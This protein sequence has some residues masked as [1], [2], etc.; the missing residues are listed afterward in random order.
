MQGAS[1]L[2]DNRPREAEQAFRQAL[3]AWQKLAT[4][5]PAAHEYTI[6]FARAQFK[7]AVAL[8]GPLKR[9][10]DALLVFRDGNEKLKKLAAE[11]PAEPRYRRELAWAPRE[12]ASRLS[13]LGVHLGDAE[14]L[15]LQ[16]VAGFNELAKE[17]PKDLSNVE[18]AGHSYRYLG[19]ISR[20]TGRTD[21][22]IAY[23]EK[24]IAAFQKLAEAD[25]PQKDGYYREF[26]ADTLKELALVLA[27]GGHV[28][29]A[30]NAYRRAIS[31]REP[32]T[33]A[34]P[35]RRLAQANNYNDLATVLMSAK[36]RPD[37]EEASRQAINL[38]QALVSEFPERPE[39]RFHLI[40]SY[41][42]LGYI[43]GESG[44]VSDAVQATSDADRLLKG[45]ASDASALTVLR[46]Q[47]GH[48]LWQLSEAWTRLNRS[49][50]ALQANQR[51]LESFQRLAA[52]HPENPY[53]RQEQG[54][55]H[56]KLADSMDHDGRS[57]DA[58]LQLRAALVCYQKL[59]AESPDS[60]FYRQEAAIVDCGLANLLLRTGQTDEA[61]KTIRRGIETYE[62]LVRDAPQNADY[63]RSAAAA[64]RVLAELFAQQKKLPEALAEAQKAVRLAPNEFA[65]QEFLL[66][67]LTR[68]GDKE[69]TLAILRENVA[70]MPDCAMAHHHLGVALE[71]QGRNDEAIA[72][73]QR[74]IELRPDWEW[75]HQCIANIDAA[76]GQWDKA[77]GEYTKTF[78]MA[79][80]SWSKIIDSLKARGRPA[81]SAKV[82]RQL[83]T[84]TDKRADEVQAR[85][86][87]GA[88]HRELGELDKAIADFSSVIAQDPKLTDPW[89]LRGN[90][91]LRKGEFAAAAEDYSEAIKLQPGNSWYWHE[92]AFAYMVLGKHRESIS[93]H[94]EVIRLADIDAGTRQRRGDCYRAIGD[95]AKAETDY[96]RAI[97]LYSGLWEAWQGRGL[98]YLQL[99][100]NDK[101]ASDF[102]KVVELAPKSAVAHYNLGNALKVKGDLDGAERAY[103]EAVRLDGNPYGTAIDALAELLLS[104]GNVKEAIATYERSVA[105]A[106][107]NVSAHLRLGN[108]LKTKGDLDAAVAAYRA[109]AAAHEKKNPADAGS[110]YNAACYRALTAA[111]QAQATG[112]DAAPLVKDEA[113][114]A[115]AWLTKAVAAGFANLALLNGD[116]DL[117]ALRDRA[118]FRKLLADVEAKASPVAR[119]G[120]YI[121]RSQWDKAA[122][123]YAKADLLTQPLRDDAFAFA[124]L[125]LIREDSEGYD[126][127]CQGMILR[128]TDERSLRGIC[129]GAH[130]RDGAKTR[131]IPLAPSSGGSRPSPALNLRGTSMPWDWRHRAG[132]LDQALQSFAKANVEAWVY[133]DLNWFGLALVHHSLGHPDEARQCLEKGNKW[134]ERQAPP[135]PDRPA[136]IL[137]QDW[138]EA[139]L[140][141]REAEEMLSIK[142]RSVKCRLCADKS[143]GRGGPASKQVPPDAT[144]SQRSVCAG[145]VAFSLYITDHLNPIILL[146]TARPRK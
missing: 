74:T 129:P 106:P 40:H 109:A 15:H 12:L 95:L 2:A 135:G 46:D 11:H 10:D 28:Q 77:A 116:S 128:S 18:H 108:A 36:R 70:A 124:C 4:D 79:P 16:S 75:P 41:L 59:V 105:L 131:L 6:E 144:P 44:R 21:E 42:G 50:D 1:D 93:D 72:E 9:P 90:C 53:Y 29:E 89:D 62:L 96:T 122:A 117:D 35:E 107:E 143:N 101:A 71:R 110:L 136:K 25:I 3:Q 14:K 47:L 121:L 88:L 137:P 91:H 85:I 7:Y 118:D 92:R 23:F 97:E 49:K 32:L 100:Q 145:A 126:R 140:L 66:D 55:S 24:G 119:A 52:D 37:A 102:A 134:L 127:L 69:R 120:Y 99:K 98:T 84:V 111:T 33:K 76:L 115:M 61:E 63:R 27:A 80:A 103:R 83:I 45:L 132:Q 125:F 13:G 142:R 78:E 65:I 87:R 139:Q 123:E 112:P 26:Q 104:R 30:E 20:D 31:V 114:R 81:E 54:V 68:V 57:A 48:T 94:S 60:A 58:E 5:F 22:A 86:Y 39:Y 82:V 141:R 113:D 133:R 67:M 43:L 130:L 73:F 34:P 56:R 138:L 19:W 8:A 51:A 64:V 146:A 17:F 38:K